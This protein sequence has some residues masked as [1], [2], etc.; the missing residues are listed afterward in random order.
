MLWAPQSSAAQVAR[1]PCRVQCQAAIKVVHVPKTAAAPRGSGKNAS[2]SH[3]AEPGHERGSALPRPAYHYH[4]HYHYLLLALLVLCSHVLARMMANAK[5]APTARRQ[6]SRTNRDKNTYP[7]MQ[8][9][10]SGCAEPPAT[11][12]TDHC[13]VRPRHLPVGTKLQ[14]LC[15]QCDWPLGRGTARWHACSNLTAQLHARPQRLCSCPL[16]NV[17]SC[18]DGDYRQGSDGRDP[19]V[20]S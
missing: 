16:G 9:G 5:G 8:K 2:D 11:G 15:V 6:A 18:F 14:P 3:S 19:L 13:I 7:G 12:Q 17:H 4:Y 20:T 1:L 10:I